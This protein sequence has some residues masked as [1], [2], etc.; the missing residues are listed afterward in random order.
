MAEKV[1]KL[2]HY[3]D[4]VEKGDQEIG[5][6]W[7]YHV[8]KYLRFVLSLA[9]PTNIYSKS[10]FP[11]PHRFL[12][13]WFNT[14]EWANS[15]KL[16]KASHITIIFVY[17]LFWFCLIARVSIDAMEL[18]VSTVANAVARTLGGYLAFISFVIFNYYRNDLTECIQILGTKFRSVPINSEGKRSW[19]KAATRTY[20]LELKLFFVY[21]SMGI[22]S[23]VPLMVNVAVT[24]EHAFDTVVPYTKSYTLGWWLEFAYHVWINVV[25]GIFFASKEFIMVG[26]LYYVSVLLRVQAEN[27][28]ELWQDPNFDADAEQKKLC[29]IFRELN[30]LME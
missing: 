2:K 16:L 11:T 17:F 4:E 28:L 6:L 15:S 5:H 22:F 14:E 8:A 7:S 13:L 29:G 27:I 21:L 1:L 20:V 23:S 24:G 3:L 10:I 25:S 9:H 12:L 26:L 30:E 19:K 18:P